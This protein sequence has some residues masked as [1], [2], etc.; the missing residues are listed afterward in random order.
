MEWDG[1]DVRDPKLSI[2]AE[3]ALMLNSAVYF[4]DAVDGVARQSITWLTTDGEDWGSVYACPSGADTWRWSTS[5]SG[6]MGYSVGYTG[7]D[8]AGTLY[9]TVD[10]KQWE[11]LVEDFFPEG[12]GN[13]TALVFGPDG[14]FYCLLRDGPGGEAHLG[15]AEPPYRE[16]T[17]TAL[18]KQIGGPEMIRLA[19]GRLLAAVRL[20][21][22]GPRT[23]VCWVDPDAGTLTEILDVPSGGDTSYAGF[24][25]YADG[26]WMSY[27]S[28]H[29]EKSAIYLAKLRLAD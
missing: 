9:R 29:E 17:W 27:Y 7:K 26:V 10:G 5:W 12:E 1:G 2:T 6:G 3:G 19:D 13:E 8:E 16:W 4:T 18:G 25:E 11:P 23:A 28:S 21:E 14:V 22:D 24:V 20:H 15:V